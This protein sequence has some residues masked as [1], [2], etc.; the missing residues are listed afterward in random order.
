MSIRCK[1]SFRVQL[2]TTAVDLSSLI[3]SKAKT[4]NTNIGHLSLAGH[5][6]TACSVCTLLHH[7]CEAVSDSEGGVN[8]PFHTAH[9]ARFSA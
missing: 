8:E 7:L 4:A 9:D 5:M 3:T 1:G 6:M 2:E